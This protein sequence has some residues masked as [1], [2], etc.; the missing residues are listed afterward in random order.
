[1]QEFIP[2]FIIL[3][4]AVVFSW[5]FAR[6][7]IPWVVSLIVGG[8]IA[9]PN[10]FGWFSGNE[11]IDFL[12]TIGLVFLMFM[13]GLEAKLSE[14]K[15]IKADIAIIGL[16]IGILPPLV[17]TGIILSFGYGLT[18]AILMGIV[19]MSPAIAMLLPQFQANNILTTKLGRTIVSSTVIID[20]LSLLLLSVFL[21]FATGGGP[22]V[23]SLLVYPFAMVLLGAF[24]WVLPRVRWLVV[25]RPAKDAPDMFERELRFTILVLIGL[26]VFFEF[27]GLHAIIAGF[28]GGMILSHAMDSAIIKAKLHAISYGFFVPIFFVSVGANTDLSVF[29]EGLRPLIITFV[30]VVALVIS[31]FFSGWIGAR[32][33]GLDNLSSMLVGSSAIPQLA[34]ALAVA[35]LGFGEGILPPELLSAVIGMVIVT[36]VVAPIFVSILSRRIMSQAHPTTRSNALS[37]MP[38]SDVHA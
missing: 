25:P 17:G 38:S 30:V 37:E 12:A 18:P 16:F 15:D 11:T 32:L 8:I 14:L 29:T 35:F 22:S 23:S 20:A 2:F 24:A 6:A 21:Q 28:F 3:L 5:A 7:R 36:S 33:S 19:F 27:I 4:I 1:M 10:G 34:T 9:G 13:A 31:K 26:V